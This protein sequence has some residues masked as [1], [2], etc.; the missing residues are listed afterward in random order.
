MASIFFH[1]SLSLSTE[2]WNYFGTDEKLGPVALS[3]RREKL[4]DTKDLKDQYQYRI[5]FRTSEVCITEKNVQIKLIKP[6]S[7]S[8]QDHDRMIHSPTNTHRL[9]GLLQPLLFT[10]LSLKLKLIVV[11]SNYDLIK[12]AKTA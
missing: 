3:I 1:L 9:H 4:E 11:C 8:N 12:S 6:G 7:C 10:S 2:H 5:I